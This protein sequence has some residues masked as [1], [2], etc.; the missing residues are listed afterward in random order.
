MDE[1]E[2]LTRLRHKKEVHR[3]C[4]QGQVTQEECWDT[5]W[6]WKDGFSKAK[7][8][9]EFNMARDVNGN[10]KNFYRN[11]SSKSKTRENMAPLLSGQGPW[12]KKTCRRL[13]F[14]MHSSSL[15]LQEKHPQVFQ[16]PKTSDKVQS[17]VD[18][19]PVENNKARKY[20][21][22]VHLHFVHDVMEQVILET[23]YRQEDDWDYSSRICGKEILCQQPYG[24]LQ[25]SD[26]LNGHGK[27]CG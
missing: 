15:S 18:S 26:L 7:A 2:L 4:K 9:L 22:K 19:L 12:W 3:S 27:S 20:F 16:A 24:C 17:D 8:P 11:V 13:C 14:S 1:Q 10:K 21:L 5:D 6:L 25:Q 23:I